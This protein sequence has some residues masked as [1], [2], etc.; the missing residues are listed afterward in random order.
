M[1]QTLTI[2]LGQTANYG[3]IQQVDADGNVVSPQ[4]PDYIQPA[5]A[6]ADSTIVSATVI[7]AGTYTLTPLKTGSTTI[8]AFATSSTE[9]DV[10]PVDEVNTITVTG[11]T[12]AALH[13][14][15][16]INS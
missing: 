15:L 5:L 13:G 4:N 7:A 11:P 8:T 1:A 3:P 6:I 14:P 12:V 16:T 2:P 9:G 10:S